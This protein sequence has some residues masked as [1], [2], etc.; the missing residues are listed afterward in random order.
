MKHMFYRVAMLHRMRWRHVLIRRWIWITNIM[1]PQHRSEWSWE[2][3]P[4]TSWPSLRADSSFLRWLCLHSYGT[5]NSKLFYDLNY[6]PPS[7]NQIFIYLLA[8][9]VIEYINKMSRLFWSIIWVYFFFK[10][11]LINPKY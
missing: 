6:L 11:V 5:Y 2:K 7:G 1:E 3:S 8:Y 10:Y 9:T 4:D